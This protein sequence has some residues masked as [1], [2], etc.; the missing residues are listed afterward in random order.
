MQDLYHKNT[1][2]DHRQ[3]F[4]PIKGLAPGRNDAW[5][6]AEIAV[7][8]IAAT[9]ERTASREAALAKWAKWNRFNS[10]EGLGMPF[11][12]R[13]HNSLSNEALAEVADIFNELFFAGQLPSSRVKIS[14]GNLNKGMLGYT[15]RNTFGD[16]TSRIYINKHHDRRPMTKQ[17][18][19]AIILHEMIH[20]YLEQYTCYPWSKVA[21]AKGMCGKL[22][23]ANI[24][25]SGH[26]R[27][28]H[29]IAKTLEIKME[30]VLGF[31]SPLGRRDGSAEEQSCGG[32]PR[33]CMRDARRLF[34]WMLGSEFSRS[35]DD[36]FRA[37]TGLQKMS[38]LWMPLSSLR[39]GPTNRRYSC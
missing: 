30:T 8:W 33:P 17:L 14:W 3:P 34:E 38:H 25:C 19:L 10:C 21:C 13:V 29:H 23:T 35:V 15:K 26:G 1:L 12:G 7:S 11:K 6:L 16:R 31:K 32:G 2:V 37:Y 22:Y 39:K 28:F 4:H 36:G 18:V 20:A 27:A 24:G 9:S 5:H